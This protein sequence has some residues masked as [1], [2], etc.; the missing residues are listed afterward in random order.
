MSISHKKRLQRA[1]NHEP[2][3][4]IPTQINYTGNMGSK[5]AAHFGIAVDQ[6]PAFLD[7]HLI[8]IGL[9]FDPQFGEN[10]RVRYDWWGAG[11]DTGEEGYYVRVNPLAG[12]KDLDAFT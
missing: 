9:S 11:Y 7:N 12:I 5:M 4:R 6:L 8:R 2:V 10:G 1:L 3:D